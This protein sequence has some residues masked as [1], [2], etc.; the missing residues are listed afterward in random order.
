MFLDSGNPMV[1]TR[2]FNS[3]DVKV[4]LMSHIGDYEKEIVGKHLLK[5]FMI[6]NCPPKN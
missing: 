5:E 3:G 1:K 4:L 2:L 6:L